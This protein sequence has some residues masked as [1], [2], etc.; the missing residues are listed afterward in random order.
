MKKHLF[1]LAIF[2]G[3]TALNAQ[4]VVFEDSFEDYEDFTIENFG[5][6][7]QEDLDG[8]QT[9]GITELGDFPNVNYVGSGII[10]NAGAI[11]A[12]ESYAPL[13]GEKALF[14]FASGA[15]GTTF[16]NDD[17]T[18]TPQISL[19]GYENAKL[20]VYAK[21]LTTQYGPDQ[22][23]IGVSTTGTEWIDFEIVS[24]TFAPGMDAWELFE[25]DLSAYDGQE[26]YV[27]IHCTTDDGLLLLM[28][29]F[30]IEA[31]EVNAAVTDLN[32]AKAAVYPNPVV[33][34]FNVELSS[35]FNANNLTVTVTDMTG[36]VV[37]TFGA[38]SSYNVSDLAAG[39]YVVKI[40]D[41]KNTDT[42][43]IVK[44]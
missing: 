41:G 31:D 19:V 21:A 39:V 30:K 2:A 38:A 33:D 36:K 1:S 12:D 16:P 8:G 17:W 32:G 27:A 3:L 4:T 20:S 28:D 6:W 11:G 29:D 14:F 13:T 44:K 35:K 9:W 43:K 40:T 42:K 37:K 15:N 25:V 23:E 5:G 22:F 34:A 18:V 7:V 10:F 24:D 26:I